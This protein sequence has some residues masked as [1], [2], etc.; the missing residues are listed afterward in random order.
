MAYISMGCSSSSELVDEVTEENRVPWMG[1]ALGI[2]K[3][4]PQRDVGGN[5]LLKMLYI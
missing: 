3:R 5:E 4:S 1:R 2:Q